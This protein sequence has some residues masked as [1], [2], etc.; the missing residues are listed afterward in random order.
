MV[1]A[2][3]EEHLR[4]RDP[5]LLAVAYA[6]LLC[7]PWN[8]VLWWQVRR[9]RLAVEVDCDRRVTADRDDPAR[10][11]YGELLLEIGRGGRPAP[12]TPFARGESHVGERI[13]ELME[14]T[15]LGAAG[16][17]VRSMA[18]L[19][20]TVSLLTIPRPVLPF[21][22]EGMTASLEDLPHTIADVMPSCLD[23]GRV[24]EEVRA[25]LAA[26]GRDGAGTGGE[27]GVAV[28]VTDEGRVDRAVFPEGIARARDREVLRLVRTAALTSRWEPGRVNGEPTPTWVFLKVA[29]R[30]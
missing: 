9:L 27:L 12:A 16:V 3:E 23:C 17:A 26:A 22:G 13:R 5:W 30:E 10:A 18:V 24:R 25:G 11:S 14:P 19:L 28:R 21:R 15:T 8:P 7:F 4:R 1:L 20:L 29:P 6:S 2:H